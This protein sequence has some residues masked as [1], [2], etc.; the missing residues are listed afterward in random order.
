MPR[1]LAWAE[2]SLARYGL[3][4]YGKPNLRMVFCPTVPRIIGGFWNDHGVLEYRLAADHRTDWL[5]EKW[6][7][8]KFWGDPVN[9]VK[10]SMT[11]EGYLSN[12]P[13]PYRGRYLEVFRFE[14]VPDPGLLLFAARQSMIANTR[15][16]TDI[17]RRLED[18]TDAKA[19]DTSR[20]MD[21]FLAGVRMGRFQVG[22]TGRMDDPDEKRFWQIRHRMESNP[23]MIREAPKSKF[24]Q[25]EN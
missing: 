24:S 11:P 13:Y 17:R 4:P 3:N 19:A 21:D 7:P 2:K 8:A 10:N 1:T 12:G 22:S 6:F 16:R 5:L 25:M 15:T 14:K 18:E 23:N 9:W 20:S